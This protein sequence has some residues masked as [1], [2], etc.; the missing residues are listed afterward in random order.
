MELGSVFK[1]L[2]AALKQGRDLH[3]LKLLKGFSVLYFAKNGHLS[4]RQGRSMPTAL[5]NPCLFVLGKQIERIASKDAK[6]ESRKL[7]YPSGIIYIGVT[8][9]HW[10]IILH[11]NDGKPSVQST[12]CR[13]L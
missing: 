11:S 2:R 7:N 4:N 13:L 6:R 1:A 9:K 12:L 5:K 10:P 3:A 8:I